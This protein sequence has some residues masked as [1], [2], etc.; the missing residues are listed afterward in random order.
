MLVHHRQSVS[1]I[2][3]CRH[4]RV[5]AILA[6]RDARCEVC[7]KGWA[8]FNRRGRRC[9][10]PARRISERRPLSGVSERR[11]AQVKPW[12]DMTA[13]EKVAEAN[14]RNDRQRRGLPL[15]ET[16]PEREARVQ[17]EDGRAEKAIQAEC[18][19]LFKAYGCTVYE[20]SQ[21]RAAKV[22]PGIPDLWVVS[23]R[24]GRAFW[25][26]TKTPSGKQSDAQTE[27]ELDCLATNTRYVLGGH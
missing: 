17:E 20:N 12:D 21:K 1:G 26:E 10:V 16:A 25:F 24:A 11:Q 14:R 5:L 4:P 3:H 2:G 15:H 6:A 13:E 19:K 27:F 18:V 22:T 23:R 7:V 9:A 8:L